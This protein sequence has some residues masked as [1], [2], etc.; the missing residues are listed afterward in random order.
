[1]AGTKKALLE[2]DSFLAI[3]KTCLVYVI[4]D[5]RKKKRQFAI[6]ISTVFLTVMVVT[7]LDALIGV[8]PTVTFISS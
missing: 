1:M 5:M 3:V 8:A 7:Y 2:A 4:N 6:G